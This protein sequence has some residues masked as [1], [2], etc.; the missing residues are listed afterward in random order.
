MSDEIPVAETEKPKK[1]RRLL[2][3]L[4]VLGGVLLVFQILFYF[5]SDLL[6]R[7]YLKE[8]VYQASGNKYEIDFETFRI[9]FIQRGIT[10]VGLK[11]NPVVGQFDSLGTGA[12]YKASVN[13]VTIKGLNYLFRKKEIVVG[14]IE[15]V[16]P[17]LE[18]KFVQSEKKDSIQ[19]QSSLEV[20]RQEIRKSFLSSQISE[21]RIKQI[22][23]SDADL[24]LRDFISQKSIQAENTYFRLMDIQIMQDRRPATPFNAEGFEFGFDNFAILLADS[25]H[26]VKAAQIRVSSLDQFIEA[27]DVH[28]QPDY[29]KYSASYFS[30]DL[31]DIKLVDAD[32]NRVFYTSEVKVGELLLQRPNFNIVSREGQK[33]TAEPK[34]FDLYSLIEGILNSVEIRD[35]EILEGSFRKRNFSQAQGEYRIKAERI[36]FQMADFYVG[37]DE[38]RKVNQFFYAKEAAVSLREFELALSDSIHWIKGE[39]VKLSS[40]EDNIRIEGLQLFPVQFAEMPRARN[41]LDIEVAELMINNANLKK[42][43]NESILDMDEV[44]LIEPKIV[45]K[46]LQA[47]KKG[48][49]QPSLSVVFQE[50]LKGIY[51]K[52]FEIR[53]GSLVMD[54]RLKIRQ[55]SLSFGKVNMVLENFALDEVTE[56]GD[57]RSFFL[58]DNLHLEFED[59]ALKLSDN[60]HSFKANRL[61]LDTKKQE[62]IIDGFSI[63][64]PQ[65][66]QTKAV[67]DSYG[68]N[69]ALDIFI[70]RFEARGVDIVDAY[71]D[72]ILHIRQINVPR[73]Q[74]SIKSFKPTE[75][76]SAAQESM[77][78]QE[79]ADLLT[80]YFDEVRV[81]SLS[82]FD[83]T[84]SLESSGA[85]GTQ[86]FS[87]K[88]IDLGIKNFQVQKGADISHMGF[89]FSEE[90]DLQ[91]NRYIFN[92]AD[93]NYTMEA[94]RINFNSANEEIIARNVKVNP[95]QDL[96]EKLKISATIPTMLFRGVDLERFL[97]ENQLG[98]QKLELD[99]ASVNILINDDVVQSEAPRRRRQVGPRSLPKTIDVIQIDT[100]AAKRAQLNVSIKEAGVQKELVNTG[101]NLN[102]F[103]FFLD[104][105]TIRKND[106]V[107]MF[108]G[109]TVG[110]EDFWLTLADS[111]HRV[112]FRN[113][114]FDTRREAIFLQNFRVI[115]NDLSG[116][117]GIPVFSGHIPALLIKTKSL[118]ALQH[119]KEISLQEVSLF[120][121]DMEVFVDQQKAPQKVKQDTLSKAG[122][123][124]SFSLAD[125]RIVEGRFAVLDKNTG[126]EPVLLRGLN[127]SL[128]DIQMDLTGTETFDPK[129]LLRHDFELSWSDYEIL[130][131]DSL[132]RIK[133]GNIK[134]NTHQ[135]EISD[136]EFLPRIGKYDY[137]RRVG[138]QTDV[139]HIS[140]EKITI[141]QPDYERYVADKTLVAK[142]LKLQGVRAEM[143]RDKRYPKQ[144]NVFK[145]MPQ[146]LMKEAGL[147]LRLDTLT[148]EDGHIHYEEFPEKGLVPGHLEFSD[149]SVA[150][151]PFFV[152]TI[153]GQ[154]FPLAESF[155]I[156]NATLNEEAKL[157]M[158]GHLFYHEPYPM[159]INAQLGEFQVGILNTILKSN[160]FARTREGRILNA[161]WSFEADD[162]EAIGKMTFLYEDLNLELLNERTLE[163]GKGKKSILTFVLNT[164]AVR[165]NNPRG[166]Q[167]KPINA[168]IYQVRDKEKFIFNYWWKTTLSG[169]KGS[170]GLGQAQKPRKKKAAKQNPPSK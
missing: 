64:P 48:S 2:K 164:F 76:D 3:F 84:M 161:D 17:Q 7:N 67:L 89:L 72:G 10:F 56:G 155:L 108:S 121:P 91:L 34:Q 116:K 113:V 44:V 42:T 165:S 38:S 45:L 74:I 93:G 79:I 81:D 77:T 110:A 111:V 59:Y 78:R 11:V 51:F 148:V 112:T 60:L 135:V 24:L 80:N 122:M 102:F 144:Q 107:G 40:F 92:I 105:A 33:S 53:D 50:Y 63:R 82:L 96:N 20:L 94:E 4:L 39:Y 147:I 43:Y 124:E 160:A 83:G 25:V 133:I 36:D 47:K 168:S 8:K 126:A 156:A 28:I 29:S 167:R 70:P 150:I 158:Q 65:N 69:S 154:G 125:F 115:P 61:A 117:P 127:V 95:R 68:K 141:D 31:D 153:E 136:L 75:V 120:R 119:G 104:S 97:F 88:D 54:N 15:L 137:A 22:S 14:D 12:Y 100:I 41:I 5:G 130:L 73:P 143:F 162:D 114:Q 27:K 98:L 9:L 99:D 19:R 139:A 118:E 30:I 140:V 90:V 26:T 46:D 129:A 131:K 134:M 16:G 23:I 58:A 52:R 87:D 145:P 35:F 166:Y 57:D 169:I 152:G 32:I 170:L 151:F 13:D 159:R 138:V 132:N 18:F 86:S 128:A 55:D 123:F 66:L 157:N 85:K 103:D 62:I 6:L 149:L 1:R 142:S 21:I 109:V 49:S 101:I 163:K 146:Q 37:P 71:F 106:F